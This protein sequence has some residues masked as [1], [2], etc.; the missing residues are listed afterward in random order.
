MELAL[1]RRAKQKGQ[2][3]TALFQVFNSTGFGLTGASMV[4]LLALSYGASDLQMSLLYAGI[5]LMNFTA[6]LVPLLLA[7]RETTSILK[8]SI[9]CRG[10]T[11]GLYPLVFFL[12]STQAKVWAITA[13]YLAFLFC[14]GFSMS[15]FMPVYKGI[16]S[17]RDLP[18]F[19]GRIF[20]VFN[21]GTLA[22]STLS[23]LVLEY[24]VTHLDW[25]AEEHAFLI[26]LLLGFVLNMGAGI[27]IN[28]L[29]ATGYLDDG[30]AASMGKAF[31]DVFNKSELRSV[32]LVSMLQTAMAIF[33]TFMM[34]YLKNVALMSSGRIFLLTAIGLIAGILTGRL[35]KVVG[36][37]ITSRALL[38]SAH[39]L[40]L[41]M[42]LV[43]AFVDR[44]GIEN[45]SGYALLQSISSI[46]LAGSASL[47]FQ[48]Q[49]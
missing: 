43:W 22:V 16:C 25:L 23:F 15:A 36:V 13:I 3:S 12:P 14:R 27:T 29:P 34:S 39:G 48:I 17:S 49:T 41:I 6:L 30:S 18:S 47:I 32:A 35:I 20:A 24:G 28:R 45:T 2:D 26:L 31:R 9:W 19:F 46:G 10:L 11:T 8:G 40:L 7:G 42:G 1:S 21:T 4:F 33:A 5:Y 38:F 44:L 37:R